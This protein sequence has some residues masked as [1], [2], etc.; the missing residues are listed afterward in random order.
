[1]RAT[2]GQVLTT[3][4]FRELFATRT[5]AIASDTL[6]TV[7]LS[8]AIFTST[9][10]AWLAALAFGI[11][12][13]PQMVSGIVLG[14]LPDRIRPRVLI[15]LG[16]TASA[17]GTALL[18]VVDLPPWASLAV[19]GLIGC[20][21]PVFNGTSGRLLAEVLDGDAYV[22]GRSLFSM[23]ASFAQ[24]AGLAFGGIAVAAA[25]P[26]TALLISA[27]CHVVAAVAVRLSLPDLPAGPAGA[28]VVRQS[29]R[30]TRHLLGTR[31]IRSLLIAQWLP[32]A[33]AIG[34]E[35][36]L[37]PYANARG[38]PAS[39]GG[40]ML[41]C[42]PVGMLAGEFV[43]AKLVPPTA[44]LRL[45][46]PLV[47]MIGTPLVVLAWDIP[48]VVCCVL[49]TTSGAG[50]AYSLGLAGPFRDALPPHQRGQAFALLSS[51]LMTVQGVSPAIWGALTEIVSVGQAIA[52][53][54]AATLLAAGFTRRVGS[55]RRAVTPRP[56]S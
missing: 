9:G 18:G 29:L 23:A 43:V 8:T 6:R 16:Y 7:A 32:P 33:L 39:A 2:F 49:L 53:A 19:V 26:R 41:A 14:A 10:S 47:A 52:V 50:F 27:G 13:A 54:G 24:I 38:F 55:V 20:L 4:V 5:L 45:V 3:P 1:M 44:R 31:S 28:N 35:S 12:F 15:T 46:M 51:G 25:N 42:I 40:I 56:S 21:A 34:G 22:L 30:A 37:V 11:A 48:L 17:A 36:L